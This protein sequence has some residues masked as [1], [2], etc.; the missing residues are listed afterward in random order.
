MSSKPR[1]DVVPSS[2][3]PTA[4]GDCSV[5]Q[6]ANRM[7]HWMSRW[8]NHLRIEIADLATDQ[9]LIHQIRYQVFQVEQGVSPALEFDGR[10]ELA[11]HLLA[12]L[13][14]RPVGTARLRSLTAQTAKIERLAVLQEARGAGIGR[15]IVE[16]ALAC[17]RSAGMTE[18]EIHAQAHLQPFY[19]QL[20]FQPEGE[21]F[22]EAGIPHVKMRRLL[23]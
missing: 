16:T 2:V 5:R 23:R 21:I 6:S 7:S 19:Q 4:D 15:K 12:Y 3:F 18:V 8:M 20:G 10:D 1:P 11:Q 17:L 9:P 13:N 22:A 14:D